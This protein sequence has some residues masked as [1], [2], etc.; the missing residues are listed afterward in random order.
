M[1]RPGRTH[2]QLA[3]FKV[4]GGRTVADGGA[5]ALC[6]ARASGLSSGEYGGR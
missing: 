6:D 2:S 3:V 5:D 1:L 4:A